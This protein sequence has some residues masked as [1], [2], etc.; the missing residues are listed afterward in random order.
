MAEWKSKPKKLVGAQAPP[1][2]SIKGRLEYKSPFDAEVLQAWA[3]R[4]FDR[5]TEV[6]KWIRNGAPLG[7]E[8]PIGT[9]GIFPK[10]SSEDPYAL[11]EAELM[12]AQAQLSRGDI[13]NYKSVA[14]T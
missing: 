14:E 10:A 6:P 13:T 8:E 11:A 3:E 5:E 12:D 7:I 9:C 2:L 1:S 4:G